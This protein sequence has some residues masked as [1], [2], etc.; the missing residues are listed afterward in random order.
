[1]ALSKTTRAAIAAD[2]NK[3]R[4]ALAEEKIRV[5]EAQ[6]QTLL[7][8]LFQL[9][10]Q[11]AGMPPHPSYDERLIRAKD[12][13]GPAIIEAMRTHPH[14]WRGLMRIGAGEWQERLDEMWKLVVAKIEYREQQD[15]RVGD[16]PRPN[17][18]V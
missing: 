18:A 5:Q 16:G 12:A 8:E 10:A 14:I 4:L 9:R 13:L 2:E 11:L 1:M 15:T 3:Q 17:G 6:I 7:A